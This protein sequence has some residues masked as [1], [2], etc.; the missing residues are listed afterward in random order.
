MVSASAIA[1]IIPCTLEH[2]KDYEKKW[3]EIGTL[4]NS[5]ATVRKTLEGNSP[6]SLECK[7]LELSEI[8]ILNST[9]HWEYDVKY[10]IYSNKSTPI[11]SLCFFFY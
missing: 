8:G 4:W 10:F 1:A 11:M 5:P 3:N 7:E 9:S 2:I 6:G